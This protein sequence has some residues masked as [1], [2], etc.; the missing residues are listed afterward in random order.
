MAN[1]FS[2]IYFQYVFAVKG[3]QS[4]LDKAWRHEVFRYIGGIIAAKGHKMIIANGVSDHVHILVSFKPAGNPSE[5]ARDIKLRSAKFINQRVFLST[6]FS[7]Q[8]RYGIFSYAHS[9]KQKIADYI[10]RQEIHHAR[11]SFKDEYLELLRRMDIEFN[12]NYVFEW[13]ED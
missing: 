9:Q 12:D 6:S 3:R 2:Q 13:I 11:I 5:L 7:W 1:T 10:A 4:M 8:T